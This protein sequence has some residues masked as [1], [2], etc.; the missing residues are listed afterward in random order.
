MYNCSITNNDHLAM[1]N[2][3]GGLLVRIMTDQPTF[4]PARFGC[5][6][7]SLRGN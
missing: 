1:P 4:S 2:K 6:N 3:I 5:T 7:R